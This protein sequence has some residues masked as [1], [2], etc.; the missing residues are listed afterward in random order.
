LI[1]RLLQEFLQS[2]IR[3]LVEKKSLG[4]R[5]VALV[6]TAALGRDAA[7]AEVP[8]TNSVARKGG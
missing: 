2:L 7:A 1:T 5:E 4:S 6:R 3:A 8:W